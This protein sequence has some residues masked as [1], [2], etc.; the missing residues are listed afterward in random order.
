MRVIVAGA[1][2]IGWFIAGKV[3]A[4]GHDVTIIDK[5]ERRIRQVNDE[6]DVQAMCGSAGSAHVLIKAGIADA[7]LLVA[8]TGSD[9]TNIVCGSLSRKLGAKQVVTRVDEVTYRKAPEI[10]Y[11]DHFGIDEFI[12]PEMLAAL[13]LA[14]FVRNPGSLA[15]EHFARGQLE[16]QQ[17]T[18]DRGSP[19]VGKNL[20]ELN[21]PEGVKVCSIERNG[22]I[23]IPHATDQ[24]NH[25]DII[26]LIGKTEHVVEARDGFE[27][28]HAK[29]RKV[30]IMG[31]G[32][33]ALSLARR[34][35]TRTF[36]LTII[37]RDAKRCQVLADTLPNA[38][39]LNGDA[40]SLSFLKE[41]H[42]DN[43]DIFIST[44]G[45]DEANIMGAIQAKNLGVQKVLVV[46]HRP[47]YANLMEKIGID[48]A[49]SPRVVMAQDILSLLRKGNEFT[50]TELGNGSVEILQLNVAGQDFVGK[51]LRDI[52][53]PE[54]TLILT[55]QRGYD[56]MVPQANTV[57]QLDDTVLVICQKP[58]HKKV[59]KLIVGQ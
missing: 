25:E 49:I 4:E 19:Y 28:A 48:R 31:G 1:G 46:I 32:H 7:D 36:R 13:E 24:I 41:E 3:S 35:R 30:V 2:E 38:T 23:I 5:D 9:E 52:Q 16:M 55:L 43:A 15:V 10:S 22:Q 21:L 6:L 14:S 34:L 26:T 29:T 27:A 47:D 54:N 17:L 58:Q 42:I 33:T 12:S 40:T 11:R 51:K 50:L 57:F 18:A 37:E 39:I 44:S 53:M 59:V 45:S 8:V 56:V 20:M